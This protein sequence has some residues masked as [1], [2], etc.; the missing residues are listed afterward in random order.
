MHPGSNIASRAA[1][2]PSGPLL[3]D[4]VTVKQTFLLQL[5]PVGTLS[6]F[7]LY[8]L[9]TGKEF[10]YQVFIGKPENVLAQLYASFFSIPFSLIG[11]T[12]LSGFQLC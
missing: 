3:H 9:N 8:F 7:I 6:R 1:E 11:P 10:Q 2:V 5:R 12:V 4:Q